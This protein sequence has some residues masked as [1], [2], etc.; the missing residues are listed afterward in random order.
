MCTHGDARQAFRCGVE[1]SPVFANASSPTI[2]PCVADR[3]HLPKQQMMRL[4]ACCRR[5]RRCNGRK[6]AILSN[7]NLI[8]GDRANSPKLNEPTCWGD[9]SAG[10]TPDRGPKHEW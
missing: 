4:T 6:N 2:L 3:A 9:G 7:I 8:V 1:R 5:R 10:E